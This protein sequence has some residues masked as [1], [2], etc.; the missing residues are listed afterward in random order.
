MKTAIVVARGP[1]QNHQHSWGAL[2]AE[3]MCKHSWNAQLSAL[4]GECDLL[5]LWSARQQS[6]IRAQLARGGKVCILERGYVGDRFAWT[7]VSFG[8]GLN[9]HGVFHGPFDDG[10]RWQRNFPDYMKPWQEHSEGYVLL[11][12]QVRTDFAV[13]GI[14]TLAWYSKAAAELRAHHHEVFFRQH[15]DEVRRRIMPQRIPGAPNIGGTLEEA[16]S[17]ARRVVT[18]NSNAAVDSILAGVPTVATDQGSM[19]WEVS[20]HKVS[21][22]IVPDRQKWAKALAW[23]QWKMEEFKSGDCWH[24]VQSGASH[25]L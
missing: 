11:I 12:G 4:P 5:V 25:G 10:S 16:M 1:K 7:S 8:G 9:G 20:G 23:K 18:F 3:G 22:E 19:A 14:D 6:A 15:P 24:H 21:E 2:F 13:R 17:G